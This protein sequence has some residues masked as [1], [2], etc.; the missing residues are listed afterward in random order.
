MSNRITKIKSRGHIH[1]SHIPTNENPADIGSRGCSVSN[2]PELCF[3][4][5]KWLPYK[6][7]W[8]VQRTTQATYKTVQEAKI[9]K[10]LMSTTL[11][12]NDA[13]DKLMSKFD[14]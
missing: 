10:E 9:I 3:L 5:P 14:V 2:I 13:F 4:G 6:D 12:K 1:W 11:Q 7:Q 8:P